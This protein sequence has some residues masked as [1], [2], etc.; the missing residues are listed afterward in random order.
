M[1]NQHL[2][3]E[4]ALKTCG[5][6]IK[7]YVWFYNFLSP[8]FSSDCDFRAYRSLNPIENQQTNIYATDDC[9]CHFRG[10]QNNVCEIYIFV[11]KSYLTL[12]RNVSNFMFDFTIFYYPSSLRIVTSSYIVHWIQWKTNKLSFM[13][14]TN[15][16]VT[17]EAC[18]V[19][20]VKSTS[21]W[22]SRIYH[23][24]GMYQ[25]WCLFYNFLSLFLSP[26]CD[27]SV[28]RSLNLIESQQTNIYATDDCTCNF[29]VV[30]SNVCGIYI[31]VRNS[32]L[33]LVW[34]VLKIYI[35]FYNLLSPLLSSDCDFRVYR[36]LN[37]I[38]NQQIN[39]Y[40]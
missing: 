11:R 7:I 10:V 17:F 32:Y 38:E 35:W 37:P 12:V 16:H 20:C 26:D 13:L 40:A 34:N 33:T 39:I 2:C 4:V 3:E 27:F 1:W 31:F 14:Q 25:N 18:K 8:F 36:S 30:H 21:L 29:R 15:A 28:Y 9:T 22:G 5:E 19:M 23:L 6:C 24:W